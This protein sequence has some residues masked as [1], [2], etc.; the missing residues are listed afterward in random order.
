MQINYTLW[1]IS[2]MHLLSTVYYFVF[3]LANSILHSICYCVFTH[4]HFVQ[5][6]CVQFVWFCLTILM[7]LC[8]IFSSRRYW[9]VARSGA[10]FIPLGHGQ[11]ASQPVHHHP[12]QRYKP[13]NQSLFIQQLWAKTR[14]RAT[15]TDN[16]WHLVDEKALQISLDAF[17]VWA[18]MYWDLPTESHHMKEHL[19]QE[20][21]FLT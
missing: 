16:K 13:G 12:P 15:I 20:E 10:A 4:L 11:E 2:F 3:L 8:L 14:I 5:Q 21:V 7:R 17:A 18:A 9:V 6:V 19:S 1:C